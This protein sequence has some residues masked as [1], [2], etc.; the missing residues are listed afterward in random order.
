MANFDLDLYRD[1]LVLTSAHYAKG[2]ASHYFHDR[3][4]SHHKLTHVHQTKSESSPDGLNYIIARSSFEK[5][6]D[7]NVI[8]LSVHGKISLKTWSESIWIDGGDDH[9]LE[10]RKGKIP[11]GYWSLAEKLPMVFLQ[12]ELR[13]GTLVVLTGHSIGG[14][15]AA[16]AA[17]IL[18][19]RATFQKDKIRCITFGSPLF[20]NDLIAAEMRT[21]NEEKAFH[22]FLCKDDL[23]PRLLHNPNLKNKKEAM[24]FLSHL[25]F[26]YNEEGINSFLNSICHLSPVGKFIILENNQTN[27]LKGLNSEEANTF[28]TNA[29]TELSDENTIQYLQIHQMTQYSKMMKKLFPSTM[30]CGGHHHC[31]FDTEFNRYYGENLEPL[32]MNPV[33]N[34][35]ELRI[36]VQNEFEGRH[37]ICLR[38]VGVHLGS[39]EPLTEKYLNI[40]NATITEVR[41][42]KH[43]TQHMMYQITAEGVNTTEEL[44]MLSLSFKS[45]LPVELPNLDPM[46]IQKSFFPTREARIRDGGIVET[47]IDLRH[48]MT[49]PNQETERDEIYKQIELLDKWLNQSLSLLTENQTSFLRG[50]IYAINQGKEIDNMTNRVLSSLNG[51]KKKILEAQKSI[52]NETEIDDLFKNPRE[53]CNSNIKDFLTHGIQ[54]QCNTNSSMNENQCTIISTLP[55]SVNRVNILIS[56]AFGVVFKNLSENGY[57]SSNLVKKM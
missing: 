40:Q 37:V 20:V 49:D 24:H 11:N 7:T 46:R 21:R 28:L 17:L 34:S 51:G 15:V 47:I 33:I 4:T 56:V 44:P 32:M 13:K 3:K 2:S 35:N 9:Y 39:L 19:G 27:V 12:E 38:I 8:Y 48:M 52:A 10:G 30:R 6:A 50:I 55:S 25:F 26:D 23:A 14:S 22:H 36:G 43:T 57:K 54:S 31:K 42:I 18:M 45:R 16:V 5:R 53:I 29:V 41:K 1:A